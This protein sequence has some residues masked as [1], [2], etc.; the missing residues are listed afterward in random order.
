MWRDPCVYIS[1][2]VVLLCVHTASSIS[3]LELLCVSIA[4]LFLVGRVSAVGH[5]VHPVVTY[6]HQTHN[7]F[8][9][10]GSHSWCLLNVM[11]DVLRYLAA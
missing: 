9:T 11:V 8:Q 4:S 1:F 7:V 2:S 10:C 5:T 3:S 6:A